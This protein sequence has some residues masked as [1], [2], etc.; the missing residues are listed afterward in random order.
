MTA[1][2]AD[3]LTWSVATVLGVV[4]AAIALAMIAQLAVGVGALVGAGVAVAAIAVLFVLRPV[5]GLTAFAV[6]TLLS[7][8][9]EHWTGASLRY[10]DEAGIA[11]LAVTALVVHRR[12]LVVPA[13]GAAELG[14]GI[15]LLA[16]VASSLLGAVPA[17]VWLP[18]LALLGKGFAF[19]YLVAS[20]RLDLDDLRRVVATV[21]VVSLAIALIGL[22][23]LLAR[24]LADEL[25]RLPATGRPRG[26]IE[27]I[28][29][30]FTHPALFGWLTAFV[31]LFLYARFAVLRSWWSLPLALAL[32]GG[33]VLSGR[34]TPVV[35]TVVGLAVGALRQVTAGGA[36]MRA[37][38]LVGGALVVLIAASV[39]LLGDFYRTTLDRYGAQMEVVTE[40]FADD[41]DPEVVGGLQPRVALYAGSLAVARDHLPLGAGVG[42][43]ASHMSREEYSPVYAEYG[44]DQTYG[45]REQNPIAVTD[46]F[47]P[48]ILGETG[49]LGLLGALLFLGAVGVRLWRAAVTDG[50]PQIHAFALGALLVYVEA[51]VRSLTSAVFVAP[52]IAYFALGAAGLA[53]AV[54]RT[55][56][57]A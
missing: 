23:Q 48:M 31:S 7:D 12:R 35:G 57:A 41:P 10:L 33:T 34:R 25:L 54:D 49:V 19:F 51:L 21:F 30:V 39:P 1:V 40:V 8:S 42:R 46:T 56:R 26:G 44:L 47:W 20:L 17:G 27:V 53:L 5:E 45:L 43:Y 16:G 24:D 36:R 4:V 3:G 37:W 29:S 9:A 13:L 11:A 2:R 6:A 52:P 14:L 32:N 18:G 55:R 50:D 28:G 15:L 22:F 38:A